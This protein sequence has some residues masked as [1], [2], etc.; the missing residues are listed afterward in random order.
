MCLHISSEG[1]IVYNKSCIYDIY[2][3]AFTEIEVMIDLLMEFSVGETVTVHVHF[4]GLLHVCPLRAGI[5]WCER[6]RSTASLEALRA[7]V[8][9]ILIHYTLQAWNICW[10]FLIFIF[11]GAFI[12]PIHYLLPSGNAAPFVMFQK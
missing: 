5:R 2:G 7:A 12:F 9:P 4:L 3:V 11:C 10:I 8:K 1:S 6:A